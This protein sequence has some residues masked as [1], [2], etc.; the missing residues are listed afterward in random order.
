V[1]GGR[2]AGGGHERGE[3]V[4]GVRLGD[5]GHGGELRRRR[6]HAGEHRGQGRLVE[7]DDDV[8]AGPLAHLGDVSAQALGERLGELPQRARVG[9]HPV[10][11]RQLDL[12]GQR[13]RAGH[14]HLHQRRAGAGLLD[15]L[16]QRVEVA[17]Q[18]VGGAAVVGAGTR[19]DPVGRRHHLHGDVHQQRGGAADDVGAQPAAGQLGQVRQVGQL[20]DH[21]AGR[22]EGVVAGH[23]ADGGRRAGRPGCGG[24][25]H[26]VRH[27]RGLD[28]L[29]LWSEP[30]MV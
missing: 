21:H 27:P 14:L 15:R 20:A 13:P 12:R 5:R 30:L 1:T 18:L 16:L 10:A 7:L 11:A 6:Q 28:L 29:T 4:A 9:D 2:L 26:S 19:G 8:R 22:L 17:A 25:P 3:R 24:H 23:G